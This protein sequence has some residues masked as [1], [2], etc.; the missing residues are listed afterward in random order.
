DR[1]GR[2]DRL[3]VG[4][5]LHKDPEIL[6][7]AYRAGS[8]NLS[9]FVNMVRRI[10]DNLGAD[11]DPEAFEHASTYVE[12]PERADGLRSWRVDLAIATTRPQNVF[13]REL[14]LEVRLDTGHAIQVGISRK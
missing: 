8:A 10:N 9:F 12:D 14:D 7:R 11:F 2:D 5:D 6:L 4:L 13:V 3:V 1:L